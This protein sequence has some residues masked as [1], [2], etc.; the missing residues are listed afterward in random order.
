MKKQAHMVVAAGAIILSFSFLLSVSYGASTHN[1][2]GL[3]V[4]LLGGNAVARRQ[5]LVDIFLQTRLPRAVAGV[6]VGAAFALAATLLQALTRN[7]LAEPGLLGINAGAVLGLAIGLSYFSAT[8]A[9]AFMYW[10]GGGALGA[11]AF[12]LGI[13][14]LSKGSSPPH[15]ILIGIATSATLGGLANYILMSSTSTLEQFRFWN[16]GSLAGVR[17]DAVAMA[18]PLVLVTCLAVGLVARPLAVLQ[19]GEGKAKT[20]GIPVGVVSF[21]VWILSA[22]LTASAVAI[23]GPIMFGGFLAAY[24]ARLAIGPNLSVQLLCSAIFG[25]S[26][27]LIADVCARWVISPYEV[28]V[29][30]VMAILGAP[31]TIASVKGKS[32]R[33]AWERT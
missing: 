10:A 26:L 25:A 31:L 5:Y 7:P 18:A 3:V 19:F 30:V 27:T 16:L 6:I 29:G 8:S 24:L 32:F 28:P 33:I 9:T 21:S 12:A 20:M 22:V 14:A 15:L 23:A 4:D 11:A 17:M 13:A 2:S 1:L